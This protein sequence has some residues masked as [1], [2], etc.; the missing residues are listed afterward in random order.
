MVPLTESSAWGPLRP[1]FVLDITFLTGPANGESTGTNLLQ[2]RPIGESNAARCPAVCLGLDIVGAPPEY[3]PSPM[4]INHCGQAN[5]LSAAEDG[6]PGG[7]SGGAHGDLRGQG[8][9]GFT[10][11]PRRRDTGRRS[12]IRGPPGPSAGSGS[13]S[14]WGTSTCPG[15]CWRSRRGRT[16]PCSSSAGMSSLTA[17]SRTATA[18][19]T[20]RTT[21][22]GSRS[23]ARRSWRPC[24]W[25][26]SART[27]SMRM[28]GR[29][30]S[31]RSCFARQ[32]A[33]SA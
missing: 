1:G 5:S 33:G 22:T 18:S 29:P 27:S 3:P 9:R 25:R 32:S 17:A 13:R 14:R 26:T 20:T 24:A 28:T 2:L 23:S 6:R 7:R 10:V 30:P 19:A 16:S 12:H 31:C 21:R 11:L 4:K 15:T 8:Q